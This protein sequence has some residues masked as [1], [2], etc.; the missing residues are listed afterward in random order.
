MYNAYIIYMHIMHIF[1]DDRHVR[2]R[3][4]RLR[5]SLWALFFS[6]RNRITNSS[7]GS[8]N[9]SIEQSFAPEICWVFK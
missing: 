2:Y 9:Q 8:N 7:N 5:L 6:C 3:S 1:A 4:S